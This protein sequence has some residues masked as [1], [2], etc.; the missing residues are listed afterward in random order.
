MFHSS[1][2]LQVHL[3]GQI[4]IIPKPEFFGDFG[5]VLLLNHHFP[6]DY[7]AGNVVI[8]CPDLYASEWKKDS[9]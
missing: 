1:I 7:S 5:E 6:G 2:E 8:I 4:S 9:K 3:S